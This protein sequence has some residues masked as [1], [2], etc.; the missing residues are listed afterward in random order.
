[1]GHVLDGRLLTPLHML[2]LAFGS[3]CASAAISYIPPHPR[4]RRAHSTI[5]GLAEGGLMARLF[6]NVIYTVQQAIIT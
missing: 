1:M 6:M 3:S 2:S 4:Y 5:F